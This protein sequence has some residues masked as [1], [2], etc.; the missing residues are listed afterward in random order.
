MK[1]HH[2]GHGHTWQ[3][4]AGHNSVQSKVYHRSVSTGNHPTT[5]STI[6]LPHSLL[7]PMVHLA[8][9]T[10]PFLAATD[11]LPDHCSRNPTPLRVTQ[12]SP[13][14]RHGYREDK[15]PSFGVTD[16]PTLP[17]GQK[18]NPDHT[19]TSPLWCS[20]CSIVETAIFQYIAGHH[21]YGHDPTT[22]RAIRL[23]PSFL[24]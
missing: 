24:I 19:L 12:V 22:W 3:P 21:G 5:R 6:R 2:A 4:Q 23:S 8:N 16:A 14:L 7:K 1:S 15:F 18:G 10:S 11:I 9:G 17:M 13:T 20:I